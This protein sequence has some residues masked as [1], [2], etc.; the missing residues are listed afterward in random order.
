LIKKYTVIQARPIRVFFAIF[1]E[2]SVLVQL[3]HQAELLALTCG[4]R[5]VKLQ[6]IHLTLLFLG[7]VAVDQIKVLQQIVNEISAKK[8]ELILKRISYWK[9]N[10]IVFI[11]AEE[12]PTELFS[13]VNVLKN[14]IQRAGFSFDK[15]AYIPHITLIRKAMYPVKI[16]LNNPIRWQINEW[17]LVESRQTDSSMD[18]LPL[19][20]WVLK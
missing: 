10:K 1:P 5:K 2:E 20:Q 13:L 8:F 16:N 18:Y 7:Y 6:H 4:G 3:S 11:Q 19:A 17:F 14:R 9:Q 15:R 12:Y